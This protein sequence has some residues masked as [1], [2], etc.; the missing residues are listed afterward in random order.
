MA[1]LE[2]LEI[3]IEGIRL[4]YYYNQAQVKLKQMKELF[5]D[6]EYLGVET[7]HVEIV[8][9]TQEMQQVN[10]NYKTVADQILAASTRWNA[11]AQV[12]REFD[13]RKP[14]IQGI[15]IAADG[16]LALLNNRL[17][18]QGET[19]DDFRVVRVESNKVTFRYK[20]E[21]IPL[22]FRRY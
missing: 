20:G 12:R 3:E 2:G 10:K 5:A 21:D 15:V 9:L 16:K 18:R 6:G 14:N 11:R 8:K 7:V 1:Q 4:K 19:M 22:L 13:Q 17:V